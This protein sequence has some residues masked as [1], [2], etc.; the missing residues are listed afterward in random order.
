MKPLQWNK[1]WLEYSKERGMPASPSEEPYDARKIG[2]QWV[3]FWF[4][5]ALALIAAVILIRTMGRKI[6][7]DGVG[8]TS[9]QGQSSLCRP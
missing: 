8:I 4:C 1:L 7:A 9:Q 5:L 2:E 3:V 6:I